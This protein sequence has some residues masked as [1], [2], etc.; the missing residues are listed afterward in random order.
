V[1]SV[2]IEL[3][4]YEP[5]DLRFRPKSSTDGKPIVRMRISTVEELLMRE[6]E[7]EWRR[8]LTNGTIEGMD[9]LL[10]E[11]DEDA[12]AHG[13]F[14]GLL[15]DLQEDDPAGMDGEIDFDGLDLDGNDDEDNEEY[16]PLPG[17]EAFSES[18]G[19]AGGQ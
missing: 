16:E 19:R 8:Y 2:P 15:D 10:A 3:T 13:A 11:G 9:E 17:F 18:T 6:H 5:R 4:V 7:E 1:D 14:D 12:P